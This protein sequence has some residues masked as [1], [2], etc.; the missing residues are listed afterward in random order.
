MSAG[1][2]GGETWLTKR[3]RLDPLECFSTSRKRQRRGNERADILFKT[4]P[5]S[6]PAT[7]LGFSNWNGVDR[8]LKSHS[9]R[10]AQGRRQKGGGPSAVGSQT[11]RRPGQERR[12]TT[13]R[14][15][16]ARTGGGCAGA[17]G[18]RGGRQCAKQ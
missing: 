14:C 11:G 7:G 12:H 6:R 15:R 13:A 2:G 9:R 10:S 1:E 17:A 8:V 16:A 4:K 3:L 5:F 18:C